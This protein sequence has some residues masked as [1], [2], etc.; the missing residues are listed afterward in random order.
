MQ[1][2]RAAHLDPCV[3]RGQLLLLTS[4]TS[5]PPARPR[6]RASSPDCGI[7]Q[8]SADND[9]CVGGYQRGGCIE[10]DLQ[11]RGTVR[12]EKVE[13]DD[14]HEPSEDDEARGDGDST[15][16]VPTPAEQP[17]TTATVT[18]ARADVGYRRAPI[19]IVGHSSNPRRRRP[20]SIRTHGT[21]HRRK[22]PRRCSSASR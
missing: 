13:V 16:F 3:A 7:Q 6:W 11:I 21:T 18:T 1:P 8:A 19:V 12:A 15:E 4:L 20:T 2:P 17:R 9:E 10:V 22:C 5:E 14:S